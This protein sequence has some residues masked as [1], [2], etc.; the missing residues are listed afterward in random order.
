MSSPIANK[1]RTCIQESLVWLHQRL[2]HSNRISKLAEAIGAS[3]HAL[4]PTDKPVRALDVGCGDMTVAETI[5]SKHPN[6]HWTCTDI[7]ELPAHLADTEKWEKYRRFDGSKLPF[8]DSS[9]DAVLFSDVLHHC[10]PLAPALL[11]EAARTGRYVI[12]KDHFERGWISR[13]MLRL[14]DFIGNHG[15]GVSVPDRYFNPQTFAATV[16]QSGL[17]IACMNN[18]VSIYPAWL[19]PILPTSLQFIAV[20]EKSPE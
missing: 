9:F 20:L 3:I 14:L 15:Y 11:Q 17:R 8:P 16:S 4:F 2:A 10:L 12:V 7:H 13:S 18:S 6:I 1:D 5:A 19:S